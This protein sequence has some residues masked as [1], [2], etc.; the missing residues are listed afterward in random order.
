MWM[1]GVISAQNLV[2]NP[3]FETFEWCPQTISLINLATPWTSASYATPDYYHSC[4]TNLSVDVPLNFGG[5]QQALTGQ[6]YAG[7]YFRGLND[8]REYIRALLTE[9]MEE[10]MCYQVGFFLNRMDQW[11][12]A[13]QAG[14][15]IS[16]QAPFLEGQTVLPFEPQITGNGGFYSDTG[17]WVE[18]SGL[19]PALGGE[20]YI[21]IGNFRNNI[22][23]IID[24]SCTNSD[25]NVYYYIDSVYVIEAGPLE[26][27]PLELGPPVEA[28]G[29]YEIDGESGDVYYTW[30]DGSHGHTL[31]VSASGVYGLTIT[32]GCAIGIDSVEVT[33][34]G[35]PPVQINPGFFSMCEGESYTITLDPDA[36]DYTWQDGSTDNVY[37]IT[38][39]GLYAVTLDD[40]C[41]LSSDEILAEVVSL[42]LPI[43]LGNDT[44]LCAG[45]NFEIM[46]DPGMNQ[47]AWQDGS[48]ASTYTIYEPGIYAVTISNVCGE[49]ADEI[50]VTGLQEPQIDLG[51]DTLGW[52]EGDI[53][54]YDFDPYL[55]DFLW[56]DGSA[57]PFLSIFNS[58]LYSV[59]V[60]N[61]CGTTQDMVTVY[62]APEPSAGLDDTI[63]L[64]SSAF[65]FTLSVEESSPV[66]NILWSTGATTSDI[67]VSGPGDYAVTISNACYSISDMV[68]LE[69]IPPPVVTLPQAN[70]ICVGDILVLDANVPSAT[71][72]W[73]DGSTLSAYEV[74][75]P[76]WYAVTVTTACGAD[77]DSTEVTAFPNLI[78]PDLGPDLGL[79]TGG[80]ITLFANGGNVTY[81]WNDL[82][83]AD[84]LV[85]TNPGMYS[86]TVQDQCASAADT[87]QITA[88]NLPPVVDLPS[89]ATLCQG[90]SL[91]I[92]ANVTG[93]SYLWS[94]GTTDPALVVNIPG[95]YSL[96]VS[97][98][99]GADTDTII[100]IDGGPLPVIDLGS[101]L[102]LC[103]GEVQSLTPVFSNVDNWLWQDGSTASTFLVST[104]GLITLEVSNA[105]GSAYDTLNASL[106]PPIPPLNLGNDTALCSSETLLLEINVS[107][108]SI[109]WFDGSHG[110]QLTITG[111]GIYTAEIENT[112]GV[113]SDT[114]IVTPLPDIPS[115][116]LGP[117]Q[118]LCVGEILTFNPGITDVQYLWQD[119][120][121]ANTFSTTQPGLVT[122]TISNACGASTDSLLITESTE[123]PQL[124]LGPDVVGC[125]GEAV[126]IQ[127]GVTGVSYTWQDGSTNPFFQVNNDAVLMLHITNA[128]GVDDD[129]IAVHF[130]TLP[131]PELGPDTVLCNDAELILTSNAGPEA[132]PVWQ[133]GS[134]SSTFVVTAA[135]VYSL[136]HVNVCGAKT[137]SIVISYLSSPTPFSLG[138]DVEIC[139]GGSV[140]LQAPL[141]MD[142]LVWQDGSDSVMITAV[143]DQLYALTVFNDCGSAYD[144]INVDLDTDIPVVSFDPVMIC[145]GDVLTLDASQPF[146][147]QYIWST[148]SSASSIDIQQP[149]EY[150][151]TVSTPCLVV[152][153]GTIVESADDCA[154]DTEYYIPNVFSPNGDQVN[155]VFTIE[156]S[157]GTEVISVAGDIID[158]WG[159]LIFSSRQHPFS[160]D[161][162]FNGKLMNPGVYVYR[163]TLVYSNGVKQ[164]TQK[165][166]GDITLIR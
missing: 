50:E 32:Q 148:G 8:Y 51:P 43:Q 124:D 67:S 90:Q 136:Q 150:I 2:P 20:Q 134:Q 56:N 25:L 117:D 82:S 119:G 126:I 123:G 41:D 36:G 60:T 105:C 14:I 59:T 34:L 89:S 145:P 130:I 120:S 46:L 137:D 116:S 19:Y 104:A 92:E 10:G 7:C 4:C 42:P 29:E 35:S 72:L 53:I 109:T 142:E 98:S 71:Y 121:I 101:D 37:V 160:W 27:L 154:E 68:Y 9:P 23:T 84:S 15:Y 100:L 118:L 165:V 65:P 151:V 159:N 152:S 95:T 93:V 156:F 48:N 112:C 127:S 70:V 83:T 5:Y 102:Q 52:C 146:N 77:H 99:C 166:A 125:E 44:I 107:G 85:V 18:I 147:A 133:D 143:N 26:E 108:V 64:C 6:A 78:P 138:P 128:C 114:L 113:S 69:I 135:G 57:D 162:T 11:C 158:R 1:A 55:G 61:Q 96:T 149:G 47:V 155:D 31:T 97:N 76:G 49:A 39:P 87:I 110:D 30:S 106:L 75:V 103:P 80:Q 91:S 132:T 40:G 86:V 45:D 81:Q 3:N 58:G 115:L 38:T 12:G 28:C 153:N 88:S 79:C 111:D 164:E 74:T 163:L 73:Q 161:G 131:D 139:P 54:S 33:F 66:D 13:N 62:E 94:D 24:P 129:T 63:R 144:E 122:L 22:E 17:A 16:T 141:T 157:A 21:T 140:L